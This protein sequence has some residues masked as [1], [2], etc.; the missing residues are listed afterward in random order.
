MRACSVT[1]NGDGI[2]VSVAEKLDNLIGCFLVGLKPTS[3]SDPYALRRQVL[4]IIKMMIEGKLSMPLKK[5]LSFSFDSFPPKSFSHHKN[6]I[7]HE[8]ETF[9]VNR[10][11]TVFQE[12]GFNKD[13]IEASVAFG[14]DDIYDAY[15]RV[16]A[17][18]SFRKN[19]QFNSHLRSV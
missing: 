8:V 5:T 6:E 16:Q 18:H 10:I 2:L 13:E 19:E 12:Y 4:G 3:S 9:I 17:L 7:I 1:T 14:I 11:K 15:C